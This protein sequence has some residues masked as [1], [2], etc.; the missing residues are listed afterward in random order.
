MNLKDIIAA[1]DPNSEDTVTYDPAVYLDELGIV[2]FDDSVRIENHGFKH[3]YFRKYF[4]VDQTCGDTVFFHKGR[5]L[6][7]TSQTGRRETPNFIWIGDGEHSFARKEFMKILNK[8]DE[9]GPRWTIDQITQD[10]R[11]GNSFND[12]GYY[13]SSFENLTRDMEI[14]NV[15]TGEPFELPEGGWQIDW[16]MFAKKTGVSPHDLVIKWLNRIEN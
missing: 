4:D 12:E 10:W 9:D 15:K 11:T 13:I 6:A 2:A 14:T 3:V 7:V 8:S 16:R 5:A 1:T